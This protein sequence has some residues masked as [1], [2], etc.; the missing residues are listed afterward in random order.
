MESV[1]NLSF[2]ICFLVPE[3]GEAAPAHQLI[4]AIISL[5][6]CV[7]AYVY[8]CTVGT[9]IRGSAVTQEVIFYCYDV[10]WWYLF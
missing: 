7:F 3:A 1:A 5:P 6:G 9:V 4:N 8:V 10:A 2:N